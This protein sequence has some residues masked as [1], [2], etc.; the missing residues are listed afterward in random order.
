MSEQLQQR[1]RELL[2]S[3]TVAAVIGW[4]EADVPESVR[5]II[6]R[7]AEDVHRLVLNRFCLNNLA[8]YLTRPE[9]RKLGRVAIVAREPDIRSIF[10]LMQEKQVSRE[11]VEIIGASMGSSGTSDDCRV[12]AERSL[13]ELGKYIEGVQPAELA[14]LPRVEELEKLDEAGRWKFWQEQFSRCIR[15]YACRQAC[16][17]CYCTPCVVEKSQPQWLETSAHGRGNFAW[18]VTRAFHLAGRCTGCGA[19][20]RACPVGIPLMLL[21]SMLAREARDKFGHVAGLDF[22]GDPAFASYKP[23]DPN[24]LFE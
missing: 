7:R 13:E 3:R 8:V 15:C 22:S 5:P 14:E 10:V 2:E 6:V 16:P 11:S 19:C 18:N 21:N 23:D 1:A 4:E 17:L 24:E 9:V 12:L 20:E